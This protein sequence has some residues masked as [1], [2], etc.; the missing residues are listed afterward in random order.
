MK[1]KSLLIKAMS[2]STSVSLTFSLITINA[3]TDITV[4]AAEDTTTSQ[5]T[6]ATWQDAYRAELETFMN[7]EMYQSKEEIGESFCSTYKL[8]DINKDGIPELIITIVPGGSGYSL[9]YTFYDSKIVLLD[10]L[11]KGGGVAYCADENIVIGSGGAGGYSYMKVFRIE[12]GKMIIIDNIVNSGNNYSN[13]DVSITESEYESLINSYESKN[14][15]YLNDKNYFDDL[16]IEKDGILY[17]YYFNHYKVGAAYISL[18]SAMI[19]DSLNGLNVNSIENFAFHGCTGLESV[20]IPK[21]ISE[22]GYGVFAE[23]SSLSSINVSDENPDYKS[24]DGVVYSKD[25]SSLV[26]FPTGK[27]TSDFTIP[28]SVN[29]IYQFAF[30]CCEKADNIVIPETVDTVF[31]GAFALCPNLK[32]ITFENSDT[33]IWDY[34]DDKELFTICN[35]HENNIGVYNGIIK[36]YEGSVAQDYA[37]NF[38][39]TFISMGED[40]SNKTEI[41]LGDVNGD[42]EINASDASDIL[43]EYAN[44]SSGGTLSIDINIAD[45]NNDG[46]LDAS[47]ASTILSYYAYKSSGGESTLEEFLK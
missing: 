22:I 9:L 4:K 28:S 19:Q 14:Q 18:T 10:T 26:L 13:N 36:G 27:K 16:T 12:N 42:N 35:S 30:S 37:E 33:A 32:S 23:C 47:D 46:V 20:T 29:N 7:S 34:W 1:I 45:V 17:D 3:F 6:Y 38:G 2:L 40:P 41:Q 15:D 39:I 24:I 11:S 21:N 44:I 8:G 43:A 25:S 5:E 31:Q